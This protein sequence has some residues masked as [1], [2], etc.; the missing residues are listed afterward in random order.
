MGSE[1]K[2]RQSQT[3]VLPGPHP[4]MKWIGAQLCTATQPFPCP[5][6]WSVMSGK[7]NE[8]EQTCLSPLLQPVHEIHA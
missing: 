1:Y 5:M 3:W 4:G 8:G 2:D 7:A 6:T